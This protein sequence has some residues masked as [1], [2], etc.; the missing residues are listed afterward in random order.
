ME[1]TN[2]PSDW[3]PFTHKTVTIQKA[4]EVCGVSRRTVYGWIASG[5]V[6]YVR[7][8]GGAVRIYADSLFH[9]THANVGESV[10]K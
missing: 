7:T 3:S 5:K 4:C 1:H 6:Q 2:A 9:E 10:R 8:A